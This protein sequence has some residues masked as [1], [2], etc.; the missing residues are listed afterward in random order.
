MIDRTSTAPAPSPG[1]NRLLGR[2]LWAAALLVVIGLA[3]WRGVDRAANQPV[4]ALAD[5]SGPTAVLVVQAGDCP[6]RRAALEGWLNGVQ[7]HGTDR[8]APRLQRLV[9]RGPAPDS[10]S[11]LADLPDVPAQDEGALVKALRR[12][13]TPG[14]PAL[15]LFD[16]RGHPLFAGGFQVD[17]PPAGLAPAARVLG[18]LTA[19]P[20]LGSPVPRGM[21]P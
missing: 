6:D 15:V 13:G 21:L 7:A 11:A 5:S 12:S 10:G 2:G 19:A 1:W 16:E 3:G 8:G 4:H 14:T 18:A 20:R 9:L 17:G